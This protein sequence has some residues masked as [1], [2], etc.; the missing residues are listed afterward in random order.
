[1]SIS[2]VLA[3]Q[4]SIAQAVLEMHLINSQASRCGDLLHRVQIKTPMYVQD[5]NPMFGSFLL[6]QGRFVLAAGS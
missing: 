2:T 6:G 1:M 5:K 3:D 4:D